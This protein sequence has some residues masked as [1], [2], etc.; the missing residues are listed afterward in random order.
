MLL[1]LLIAAFLIAALVWLYRAWTLALQDSPNQSREDSDEHVIKSSPAHEALRRSW[2]LKVPKVF[3]QPHLDADITSSATPRHYDQNQSSAYASAAAKATAEANSTTS[4]SKANL[5]ALENARGESLTPIDETGSSTAPPSAP[6]RIEQINYSQRSK[7]QT[8]AA[9]SLTTQQVDEL[10]SRNDQLEKQLK[11][12]QQE[13]QQQLGQISTLRDKELHAASLQNQVTQLEQT[14]RSS[15]ELK[16]ELKALQAA[17]EQTDKLQREVNL[18]RRRA[19]S[20]PSDDDGTE[21]RRLQAELTSKQQQNEKYLQQIDDLETRLR[22]RPTSSNEAQ[23]SRESESAAVQTPASH[24]TQS[25]DSSATQT[26]NTQKNTSGDTKNAKAPVQALFTR[27]SQTDDLKKIKGIGP[28]MER[29]LNQ[30]GVSTFEQLSKFTQQDVERVSD[31]LAVFPGRIERDQ[32]VAQAAR[33][34]QEQ[35]PQES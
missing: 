25:S 14:A 12:A 2:V 16:E 26:T 1:N 9:D 19:G 5:S 32:W 22:K 30:L 11:S 33:F 15:A 17:A 24:P 4:S 34:Y 10:L 28:V 35:L 8:D 20:S 27:P 29:T 31:A 6:S 3:T 7:L 13:I 18:L 23:I 21:L